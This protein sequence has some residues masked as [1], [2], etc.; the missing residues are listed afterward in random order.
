M[1]RPDLPAWVQAALSRAIAPE[2]AARFRDMTEFAVE[3]EAGPAPAPAAVQ[4]PRTLYQRAPLRVWQAI[5]ALLALALLI[6]WLVR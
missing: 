1:L 5:A 2:P 6:S 3:F 4:Q